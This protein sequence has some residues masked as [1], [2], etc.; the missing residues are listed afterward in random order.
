MKKFKEKKILILFFSVLILVV[1]ISVYAIIFTNKNKLKELNSKESKY[2][3]TFGESCLDRVT[4]DY[5]RNVCEKIKG[6]SERDT[7]YYNE[8]IS[9]GYD[10]ICKLIGNEILN[11]KCLEGVN[12]TLLNNKTLKQRADKYDPNKRKI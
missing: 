1:L 7:C 8:G 2:Y 10:R 6:D 11:Q 5:L 9:T 3:E 12:T 4:D